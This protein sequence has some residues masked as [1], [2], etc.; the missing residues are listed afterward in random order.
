MSNTTNVIN[1]REVKGARLFA[2]GNVL[3][4]ETAFYVQSETDPDIVYAVSGNSCECPDFQK[5][6]TTCKHMFAVDFYFLANGENK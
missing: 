1:M 2:S 5:R 3:M 4:T 6:E